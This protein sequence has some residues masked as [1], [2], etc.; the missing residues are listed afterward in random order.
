MSTQAGQPHDPPCTP[1]GSYVRASLPARALHRRTRARTAKVIIRTL[2][3]AN[4]RPPPSCRQPASTARAV[5]TGPDATGGVENGTALVHDGS[6]PGVP[7]FYSLT[8]EASRNLRV[9][10]PSFGQ[11]RVEPIGLIPQ[12]TEV[13]GSIG[14][15][16]RGHPATAD[17]RGPVDIS[18]QQLGRIDPR[19]PMS[20]HRVEAHLRILGGVVEFGEIGAEPLVDSADDCAQ[21]RGH[22]GEGTDNEPMA[23]L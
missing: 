11:H 18:L 5:R 2:P 21:I 22:V 16:E 20:V 17:F 12:M 14:R 13:G 1:S 10:T 8:M 19:S 9:L 6:A 3:P 15:C 23:P 7:S 4:E